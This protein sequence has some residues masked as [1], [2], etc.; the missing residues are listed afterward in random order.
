MDFA[1]LVD[2]WVKI[3][4]SEKIDKYLDLGD[5]LSLKF[6]WKTTTIIFF[7]AMQR[8]ILWK[9]KKNII[10]FIDKKIL[11]HFKQTTFLVFILKIFFI[12]EILS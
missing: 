1:I 10:E 9:I 3:K 11:Q 2:Q 6:Q 7:K 4:E 12:L 5:L 8:K